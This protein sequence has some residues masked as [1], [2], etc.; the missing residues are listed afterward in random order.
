M[1]FDIPFLLYDIDSFVMPKG[2]DK[3]IRIVSGALH[4]AHLRTRCAEAQNWICCYCQKT[5]NHEN[6]SKLSVTLEH[7]VPLSKGGVDTY[8]NTVAACKKCNNNRGDRELKP[9]LS[10]FMP[11]YKDPE[12][13]INK[14]VRHA[15]KL[16]EKGIVIHDWVKFFKLSEARGELFLKKLKEAQQ[17]G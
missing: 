11:R 15:M 16:I 3:F 10:G 13:G 7:I 17:E 4:R 5:M 12:R 14:R 8:E 9:D 2:S 1:Q 6:G